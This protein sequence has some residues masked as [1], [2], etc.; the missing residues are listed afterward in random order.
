MERKNVVMRVWR[1][2]AVIAD[3]IDGSPTRE[4][5]S[6]TDEKCEVVGSLERTIIQGGIGRH[7]FGQPSRGGRQVVDNPMHEAWRFRV[8]VVYEQNEAFCPF[9]HP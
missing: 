6:F 7:P 2:G 9:R 8:G 5:L 4:D 3:P 1:A